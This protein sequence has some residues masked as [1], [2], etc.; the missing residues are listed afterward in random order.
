MVAP[1]NQPTAKIKSLLSVDDFRFSDAWEVAQRR[2]KRVAACVLAT[3]ALALLYCYIASPRYESA[4]QILVMRKDT[5]VVT[6]G[7][8][9]SGGEPAVSEDILATH[10]QLVQSESIVGKAL[11]QTIR[12][13]E[14][15]KLKVEQQKQE[16]EKSLNLRHM[17]ARVMHGQSPFPVKPERA[18]YT[19]PEATSTPTEPADT[20]ALST[21]PAPASPAPVAAAPASA[22][23][24]PPAVPEA[25]TAG[26]TT[27]ATPGL[28]VNLGT[29][30]EQ[31]N[32]EIVS[33]QV[34]L[35]EILAGQM[36]EEEP[37]LPPGPTEDG[38]L[39]IMLADLPGI[40][41]ELGHAEKPMQYVM[42]NLEVARGGASQARE[43][44][45]LDIEFRHTDAVESKLVLAAIVKS[46]QQ[47][48]NEKFQDVNKEAA[49]LI[50]GASVELAAELDK[51][52]AEYQR[53]REQ[54]PILFNG[55][56]NTNIHRAHYE[57]AA[58]ELGSLSLKLTES[59]S[60]LEVVEQL[61]AQRERLNLSELEL[62]ALI[63]ETNATRLS[64]LVAVTAGQPVS[65]V[66]LSKQAERTQSAVAEFS[67][68]YK[69]E[70]ALKD[71]LLDFG[72]EHPEVRKIKNR[73][74]EAQKFL[75]EKDKKLAVGDENTITT[76][77]P[78]TIMTAYLRLLRADV[79]A[80]ERR[81][82]Q[83]EELAA[84]EE[85]RAKALVVYELEGESLLEQVRRA[86]E[87]YDAVLDRLREINLARD[88]SGFVNEVITEPEWGSEYWPSLPISLAL[89]TLFGLMMGTGLAIHGEYRDRS[90]RDPEE[91]RR[92]L[93]LPLLTHVPDLRA[94]GK[95][96]KLLVEGSSV[97]SSIYAF[98]RP[99]SREAEVFRGLRTS[100][101]FSEGGKKLQVLAFT[102]PNPG[103]GKSTVTSNL[104]VS[105]AQTGR[106]VLIIDCDLRRPNVHKL[107]GL[108]NEFGLSDIIAGNSEPAD[109]IQKTE[110]ANL[111][112]IAS[113]PIPPNPSELLTSP[114]FDQFLKSVREKYDF[115]LLDCPPVLAVAD[116][117]IV[118]PRAD[119][120]TVVL[121]VS[122]DSKPQALRARDMLQRVNARILG[123][124]VN[125]SQEAAKTGYGQYGDSAYAYS[126][127]Y[128][129]R[130]YGTYHSYY[131]ED[132]AADRANGSGR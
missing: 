52:Q 36:T 16:A 7:A 58:A 50:Q 5:S 48:L 9:N 105:I 109:A 100:L 27:E 25:A 12:M 79:A 90:F 3:W 68:L 91:I 19:A 96:A 42:S 131:Q 26:T 20:A 40:L 55:E 13:S 89:A 115:V 86:R 32:A 73:I 74:A 53:F 54:S 110:S 34:Q 83:L 94:A 59:R 103:D 125:A 51:M 107:L 1:T 127:D 92:D 44:H 62:L 123:I 33:A 75:A 21:S 85:E 64:T 77:D 11:Q 17:A 84:E 18:E 81:D 24:A 37:S 28:E 119:G 97:H 46:Y 80:L 121:R 2:W 130:K 38:D 49:K 43:A 118:G 117:C 87:L 82:Q 61:L 65:E 63:D 8:S 72:P 126:Y 15:Q 124:V 132:T 95:D 120:V 93:G 116:P 45:V 23:S 22:E 66:F 99:K 14:L 108:K 71:L 106:K 67:E 10:M 78:K 98:H 69:S 4:T 114:A 6:S 88:Y 35:Q 29:G 76:V 128:G 102:S 70:A 101:F 47:F 60:R 111:W 41:D 57:A 39:V 31:A 129:G 104:A 112:A 30:E 122:R 113:G 56:E